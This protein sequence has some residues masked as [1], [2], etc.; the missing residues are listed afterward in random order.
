[1][2]NQHAYLYVE[3][4]SLS[5]EIMTMLME[6]VL[7]V[8]SLVV[9]SDSRDFLKRVEALTRKPDVFMLDIHVRPHDG[10]E[11]LKLLRGQTAY[12]GSKIIALT[13]SVMNEEIERLRTN[14]FDGAIGKPLSISTF[15]DLMKRILD[16]ETIWHVV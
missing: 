10:F 8:E 1:M 5:R 12:A 14:G 3:D 4:D 6:N 7:G 9:F 15:P 13:A 2:F 11:M 16:G